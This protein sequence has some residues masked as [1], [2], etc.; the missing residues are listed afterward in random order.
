MKPHIKVYTGHLADRHPEWR[1]RCESY[2]PEGFLHLA[3]GSTMPE[4]YAKWLSNPPY[5]PEPIRKRAK[6]G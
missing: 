6:S 1:Y 5:I 3:F 4:A 2:T